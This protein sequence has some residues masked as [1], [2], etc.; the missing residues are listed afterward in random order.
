MKLL[1][2]DQAVDMQL[3]NEKTVWDLV[4]QLDKW[5]QEQGYTLTGLALDQKKVDLSSDDWHDQDLSLISEIAIDANSLS[6]M[7]RANLEILLEY[8][9]GMH[10]TLVALSEGQNTIPRI[11][12]YL[13]AYPDVRPALHYL[14]GGVGATGGEDL[15]VKTLDRL[16]AESRRADGSFNTDILPELAGQLYSMVVLSRDRLNEVEDPIRDARSTMLILQNMLGDLSMVS[17]R[18]LTGKGKEAFDTILRFSEL[19]SKLMR[20]FWLMIEAQKP[21]E[22]LPFSRDELK[23]WTTTV[24][25]TLSQITQA[26]DSQDTVLLGDILEYELPAHIER[27]M[28]LIPETVKE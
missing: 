3:Q 25:E 24:N 7:R 6:Q 8:A 27:L 11:K 17:T 4:L 28:T 5:L 13:D 19:M 14:S 1:V 18:I 15:F 9:D 22:A 16:L 23:G 20:L 2:N 26:L 12:E 21:E 10:Q